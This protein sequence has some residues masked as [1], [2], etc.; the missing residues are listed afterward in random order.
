MKKNFIVV[1]LVVV[2]MLSLSL[3]GCSKQTASSQDT[4]TY[5]DGSKYVGE[6]KDDLMNGQ[7]T[8]TFANGTQQTGIW[9]NGIYIGA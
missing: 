2:M 7:G 3:A 8:Y 1:M 4:V 6:W 5:P 9:E